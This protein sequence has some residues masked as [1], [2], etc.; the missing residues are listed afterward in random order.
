V[1]LIE[2]AVV[3]HGRS[4]GNARVEV[5]PNG[6]FDA[7]VPIIPP[8]ERTAATLEIR[9]VAQ[10]GPPLA[11]IELLVEA[12]ALVLPRDTSMLRGTAGRT[13]VVDVLVYGP[14]DEIRGLLT[15]QD[16]TLIAQ[17]ETRIGIGGVAGWPRTIGLPLDIPTDRLPPRAR[18]HLLAFDSDGT[19]V[20]HIDSNVVLSNG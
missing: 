8:A 16:G 11:K 15:G 7:L 1:P 2:V 6:E 12:G 4:I 10:A 14:V 5:D 19:E 17:G 9:D 3:A 13:L 20:E 18:L